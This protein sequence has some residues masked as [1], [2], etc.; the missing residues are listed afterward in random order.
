SDSEGYSVHVKEGRVQ[1]YLTKRWLDDALRVETEAMLAP[2]R[3]HHVAIVYDGSRLAS[4]VKIFVNGQPQK[5]RVLLDQ[6]N[7]TF[8]TTQPLRIGAGGG[9]GNRFHGL[10]SDVRVYARALAAEEIG[11]VA[12]TESAT[13][14][15]AI[16]AA[17]RTAHQAAKLRA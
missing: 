4:G 12:V 14:L 3:W 13:E 16:S 7:Q 10:I 1:V 5:L 2:D 15:A 17:K 9:P 6:L 8:Q 11:I